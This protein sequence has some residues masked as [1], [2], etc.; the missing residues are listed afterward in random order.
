MIIVRLIGGL[1]NQM[2]EYAMAKSIALQRK[3]V[4][5]IDLSW[6]DWFNKK[7]NSDIYG[8]QYF[9]ITSRIRRK[10]LYNNLF[11]DKVLNIINKCTPFHYKMYVY[12]KN[13]NY[14]D[15]IQKYKSSFL[16][17]KEGYWQS[18]KYFIMFDHEIRKEFTFKKEYISEYDQLVD[19]IHHS[20]SVS[21]HVRRGDYITNP[22][23]SNLYNTY[24]I[25]YYLKSIEYILSKV[26]NPVFFCFSD[27][28]SWVKKN[29]QI[30][31][32]NINFIDIDSDV[33]SKEIGHKTNG[34]IDL[35][36][37]SL[38]KNNIIA[39]SSFSWWGAWLNKNPDKI[40]IAPKKWF[41]DETKDTRDL[42]PNEWVRL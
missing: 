33:Q 40:V 19:S 27:D 21:I 13:F 4:L 12:E 30:S 25:D 42:I 7:T 20:N 9:A 26:D 10:S 1:G 16:F 22:I 36:L 35:F 32:Y 11:S 38:C 8:L 14:D 23:L 5:Q 2:F 17:F 6:I 28:I 41:N 15:S 34:Y 24:S 37:M 3:D 29:L 31:H 39:N 18:Y